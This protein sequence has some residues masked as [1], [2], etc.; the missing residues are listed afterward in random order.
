MNP[1]ESH[2]AGSSALLIDLENFFLAREERSYFSGDEVYSLADDFDRLLRYV[3]VI[4]GGRRRA[5]NRAYAE[6]SNH[7]ADG[8]SMD[9]W[10]PSPRIG[11]GDRTDSAR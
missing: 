4:G 7:A 9:S 5:V 8:L 11:T 3:D 1:G 10:R 2:P 6:R